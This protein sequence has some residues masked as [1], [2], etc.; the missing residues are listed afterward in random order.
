[1]AGPAPTGSGHSRGSRPEPRLA[2]RP[3]R[4]PEDIHASGSQGKF[5]IRAASNSR[6]FPRREEVTCIRME[7]L[8]MALV[9]ATVA[10]AVLELLVVVLR[11]AP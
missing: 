6:G 8:K 1:M 7:P 3:L 10:K 4:L 11:R 5:H 2:L 9:V